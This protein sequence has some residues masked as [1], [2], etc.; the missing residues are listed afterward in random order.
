M[1]RIGRGE[2]TEEGKGRGGSGSLVGEG[3]GGD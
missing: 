2:W 3:A 1:I